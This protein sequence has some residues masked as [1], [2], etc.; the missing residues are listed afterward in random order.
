MPST[1]S[2]RC[3]ILPWDSEFFGRRIARLDGPGLRADEAGEI[4]DWCTRE[5]VACLYFLAN[6]SCHETGATAERHGFASTDLRMTYA[7][8]SASSAPAVDALVTVRPHHVSDIPTL[9]RIA[10]VAH[11]DSRFFFD[12]RFDRSKVEQLFETWVR[13]ACAED[14]VLVGELEG[15]PVGYLS[16]QRDGG[17]G[18]AAVAPGMQGQG[19]GGAMLRGALGWFESQGV[20]DLRVVTQGRNVAAHR[21]YQRA[22]FLTQSVECWFHRWFEPQA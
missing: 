13:K 6:A 12:R 17:I 22:G 10:R 19:V 8:R 15:Q 18:L 20:T 9:A 11:T 16:C 7:R 3:R 2:A 5:R 1:M 21:L 4:L 14:H